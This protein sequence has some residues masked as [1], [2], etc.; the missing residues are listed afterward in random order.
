MKRNEIKLQK[1]E[2]DVVSTRKKMN[3]LK[4][5]DNQ[6]K[7]EIIIVDKKESLNFDKITRELQYN[8]R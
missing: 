3:I 2:R 8:D 1:I 5:E 6:K 7:I 4:K